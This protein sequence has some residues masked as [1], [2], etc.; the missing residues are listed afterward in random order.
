[1]AKVTLVG[2]HTSIAG[3]VYNALYQG[4]QLNA[5]TIQIFT[6][7]QRQWHGKPITDETIEKFLNAKKETGISIIVS[8][9]N[10][11]INLGASKKN[12]L[13]ISRTSFKEEIERCHK[14]EIDYLVFHPGSA[15]GFT[16]ENCLD[17]IVE[18][19]LFFT[20]IIKK[21]KTLLLLETSAGQGTNVG[22]KF[23]Q[24][25][26]I[27]KNLKNEIPIGICLDTCHIFNAGYDIRTYKDCEK[28]FTEFSDIIGS[29]Y[30]LA[31]HLNDSKT[32]FGT[33]KDRHE[34]LGL[35]KIGYECF[36]FIMKEKKFIN[37]PKILETPNRNLWNKEIEL[38]KQFSG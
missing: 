33:K 30:L 24:L 1:M 37:M 38:L 4:E 10:Y 8:H 28:T 31:F 17:T 19:L 6:A 20:P 22:H 15:T 2:A 35:G 11:L 27:I 12:I 36:E 34:N 23:E 32:D 21:G 9:N 14:L 5:T 18:S 16:E 3:G 25:H 13:D 7:N 26:Y 29:K